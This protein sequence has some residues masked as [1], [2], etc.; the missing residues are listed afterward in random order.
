MDD[1]WLPGNHG[2]ATLVAGVV[3][4]FEIFALPFL[5][6]MSLSP[7]MRVFSMACGVAV[8]IIWS[9][10]S[11]SVFYNFPHDG[12]LMQGNMLGI[13][14]PISNVYQ[15]AVALALLIVSLYVAWGLAPKSTSKK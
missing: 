13:H 6:R 5:L 2:T 11:I 14:I 3:V 7:L 8:P 12:F 4:F 15:L 9:V 10:L 1:Y